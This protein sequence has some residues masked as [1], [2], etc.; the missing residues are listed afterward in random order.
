MHACIH[1]Y[2]HMYIHMYI[3]TYINISTLNNI[4]RISIVIKSCLMKFVPLEQNC[5]LRTDRPTDKKTGMRNLE[6]AFD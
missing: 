6:G 3:H 4:D 2:I 1:T 5:P